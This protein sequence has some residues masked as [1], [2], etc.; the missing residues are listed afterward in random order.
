MRLT[1]KYD[2]GSYGLEKVD[3]ETEKKLGQLEDIEEELGIDLITLFKALK[4]GCWIRYGFY[5]TCYLDGKPTFIDSEHLHLSTESYYC[6]RNSEEDYI[7]EHWNKEPCLCLFDME[8]ETRDKIARVQ[9]Y[10]K[11]WALTKEELK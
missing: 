4:N 11:T 6:E 10:G 3:W 8:Y 2:D 5:G 7:S 9:D 1:K